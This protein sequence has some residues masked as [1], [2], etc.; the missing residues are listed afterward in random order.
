MTFSP[1]NG[2]K[3]DV[4]CGQIMADENREI[5]QHDAKIIISTIEQVKQF[6]DKRLAKYETWEKARSAL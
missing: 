5:G 4:I 1:K 6:L 3:N 2:V